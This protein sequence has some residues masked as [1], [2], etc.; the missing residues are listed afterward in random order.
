[1][2]IILDNQSIIAPI[3]CSRMRHGQSPSEIVDMILDRLSWLCATPTNDVHMVP[4][5]GLYM[6]TPEPNRMGLLQTTA[7]WIKA[8]KREINA[9]SLTR[10]AGPFDVYPEAFLCTHWDEQVMQDWTTFSSAYDRLKNAYTGN[11][12][13]RDAVH[14]DIKAA[15]KE[16]C[17]SS[18]NFLLE[19]ISVVSMWVKNGGTGA[20][21]VLREDGKQNGIY[22]AYPGT[23]QKSMIMGLEK[24]FKGKRDILPMHWLNPQSDNAPE[25][26]TFE[27]SARRSPSPNLVN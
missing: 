12:E 22:I 8:I 19:E 4:A 18:I 9:A 17:P 7:A 13:F 1:M 3:S 2:S 25:I 26:F 20:A 21:P 16:I 11:E 10:K 6:N 23:P 14:N 27:F 5:T 15:G 24:L